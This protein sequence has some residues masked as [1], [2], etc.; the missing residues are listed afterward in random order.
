MRDSWKFATGLSALALTA[1]ARET[2]VPLSEGSRAQ[3]GFSGLSD[4]TG[5]TGLSSGPGT[6][7]QPGA[8][9]GPGPTSGST[10]TSVSGSGATTQSP[11]TGPFQRPMDVL[12]GMLSRASINIGKRLRMTMNEA[13]MTGQILLSRTHAQSPQLTLGVL[14]ETHLASLQAPILSFMRTSYGRSL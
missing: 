4:G 10:A 7:T 1:A 14:G 6:G 2:T 8:T 12:S 11:S 13:E 9:T 3:S 5:T